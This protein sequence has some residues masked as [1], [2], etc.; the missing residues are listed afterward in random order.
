M[1]PKVYTTTWLLLL[2]APAFAWY[3]VTLGP[4][5]GLTFDVVAPDA[6]YLANL[7]EPEI[8]C[9]TL[10]FRRP[11]VIVLGDS[12]TYAAWD[13]AELERRLRLR[14]GACALGGLYAESVP[15][16][17]AYALR[18]TLRPRRIVLGLSPR[19][20][21]ESPTKQEQIDFHDYLLKTM[22]QDASA[23]VRRAIF[24]QALPRDG[25][26]EAI[27]RHASRIE[28][29]DEASVGA[30]LDRSRG[31]IKTLREWITRLGELRFAAYPPHL[32]EQVCRLVQ[33]AGATLW[34]L[35]V[36]ESPYLEAHYSREVW[37]RYGQAIKA[38]APCAGK[39][40]LDP[41]TSYGLGNR[42]YVN[43]QLLDSHDYAAWHLQVP[44]SDDLAFDADHLNPVGARLFTGK[45]LDRLGVHQP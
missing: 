33:A 41:A 37:E 32:G 1:S 3:L 11:E 38:L 31:S 17:L 15:A 14:V 20:F 6:V 16:L 24:G 44:L 28:A 29:L 42:H 45:V 13:F 43:R 4:V 2:A 7:R 27:G 19:M 34:V 5:R 40:L 36:P 21:W 25:E 26:S 23:F 30:R 12:H 9:R 22:E 39:V 10:R 8:A 35:H 18:E